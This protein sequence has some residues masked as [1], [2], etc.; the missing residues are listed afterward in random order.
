MNNERAKYLGR[1][2][3][4]EQDVKRDE[5]RAAGMIELIRSHLDPTE[6]LENLHIEAVAMTAVELADLHIKYLADLKRLRAVKDIL[7]E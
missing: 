3:E 2:A 4:L 6:D 7:G 5:V 1:K